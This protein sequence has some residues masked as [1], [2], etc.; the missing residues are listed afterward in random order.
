MININKI[1]RVVKDNGL[2]KNGSFVYVL[3][4]DNDTALVC[5]EYKEVSVKTETLQNIEGIVKKCSMSF[6]GN[7]IDYFKLKNII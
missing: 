7:L 3:S 5:N 4:V 1:A 6:T 2:F